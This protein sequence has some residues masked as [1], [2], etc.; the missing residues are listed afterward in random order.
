MQ[1][2]PN[3]FEKHPRKTILAVNLIVLVA[4][5]VVF[6]LKIIN[7]RWTEFEPRSLKTM[8]KQ[9]YIGRVIDANVGRFI[10][11]RE[12]APNQEK[13]DRPSRD[14]LSHIAPNSVERKFYRIHTD[15]HGFITG[16]QAHHT[17]PDLNVVFLGGSTTECLFIDEDKRFPVL[18]KQHLEQSTGKQVNTYN[19][20]VSANESMHSLNIFINKVLPMKPDVVVMMHNIN[21]LVMLRPKGGY[22]YQGSRKSH[23]QTSKN[24]FTRF[25]IPEPFVNVGDD[26]IKQEFSAN[27]KS[28]AALAKIRGIKPVL[29]TQANRV[30]NDD[31]Y[32]EFNDIIRQVANEEG[33]LLVDLAKQ[34][35]STTEYLYDSYHYTQKGSELAAQKITEVLSGLNII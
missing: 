11:L 2:K 3:L 24:V 17:N 31:L 15:E 33:I 10:M 20:G 32:H 16:S 18:V 30:D 26:I 28:F 12:F 8:V 7:N 29:M 14:Y 34:I 9:W 19:G 5:G 23:V 27:L 13:F 1:V 21:D 25:E 35:P 6:N 22:G 4:L